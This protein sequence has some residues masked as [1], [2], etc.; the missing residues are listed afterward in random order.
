L[1]GGVDIDPSCY[2][3][4]PHPSLG[5]VDP[6]RDRVELTLTRWALTDGR[7][8]LGICRGV[9]T[10]NVAC[11][12]TLWQDIGAQVPGALDHRNQP[13]DPYGRLTH[14]VSL[15]SGS[16]LEKLMEIE[17]MRVNSLHHQAPREPGR[18]LRAIAWASDGIIEGL[19]G[20]GDSWVVG[21]Q[22]HPEWLLDNPCQA[23]LFHAF[24]SSCRE[25]QGRSL[26][27]ER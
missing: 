14:S 23:R 21:V 4:E 20:K 17:E 15:E 24:V 9:Q 10:L 11:G 8:I 12:G 2:G 22:W 16:R 18:G 5:K 1:A 19:E 3:Q 7:P 25:H 27:T 13:G 6:P 26:V